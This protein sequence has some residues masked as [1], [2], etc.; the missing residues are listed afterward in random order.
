MHTNTQVTNPLI[1]RGKEN[2]H[3][4]TCTHTSIHR[5][6]HAYIQVINA[7]IYWDKE[8]RHISKKVLDL[9]KEVDK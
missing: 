6:M 3:I 5:Y 2:R 8:N 1:N 9:R 7:L 4:H